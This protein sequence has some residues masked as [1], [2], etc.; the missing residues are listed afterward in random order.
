MES[1]LVD[2]DLREEQSTAETTRRWLGKGQRRQIRSDALR[3]GPFR[4]T[5]RSCPRSKL[6]DVTV[7]APVAAG[8][9]GFPNRAA[10]VT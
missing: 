9:T 2:K 6:A 1:P 4:W 5:T 3:R 8:S 7:H 10:G